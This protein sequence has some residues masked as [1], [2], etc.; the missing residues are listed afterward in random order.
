M[1][2]GPN[3]NTVKS[4]KYRQLGKIRYLAGQAGHTANLKNGEVTVHTKDGWQHRFNFGMLHAS[5]GEAFARWHVHT[6]GPDQN[7]G[8]ESHHDDFT[9]TPSGAPVEDFWN[10]LYKGHKFDDSSLRVAHENHVQSLRSQT[11]GR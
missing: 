2:R 11:E 8:M 6:L 7:E 1:G 3:P 4:Y 9:W 5:N 10:K